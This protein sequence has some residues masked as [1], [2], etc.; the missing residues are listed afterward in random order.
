MKKKGKGTIKN[1]L[2]KE[3]GGLGG[4]TCQGG[5]KVRNHHQR[6]KHLVC[7]RRGLRR[8]GIRNTSGEEHREEKDQERRTLWAKGGGKN[9][10]FPW[11][12]RKG[13]FS[14]NLE[15]KKTNSLLSQKKGCAVEKVSLIVGV[16]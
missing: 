10:N 16:R 13:G 12:K 15:K 4:A 6:K 9:T 7:P 14:A 5:K 3:Q 8:K 2:E 1:L 11:E